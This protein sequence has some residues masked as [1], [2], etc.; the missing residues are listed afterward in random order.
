MEVFSIPHA[1]KIMHAGIEYNSVAAKTL[2]VSPQFVMLLEHTYAHALF[3][4]DQAAFQPAK[5]A[6]YNY[7]IV[8]MHVF[9][10]RCKPGWKS[11]SYH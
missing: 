2:K 4:E 5:A 11:D 10:L 3:A 9:S 8:F 7:N 6:P 1:A